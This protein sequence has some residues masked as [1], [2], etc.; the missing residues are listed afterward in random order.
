MTSHHWSHLF[1]FAGF[2]GALLGA[3][4]GLAEFLPISSSAHLVL[5]RWILGWSEF[6]GGP[7]VE[8]AFD[9][10]LHAGTFVAVVWYFWNDLKVFFLS[11]TK[12][13][14][15]RLNQKLVA[16]LIVSTI[17]GALFGVLF[18]HATESYFSTPKYIA[19]FLLSLGVILW[20]AEA[21]SGLNRDLEEMTW[22]DAILI[23]LAQA[24]AIFP[25]FSRSGITI[26]AALFLGIKR[27]SAARYSF[28]MSIPIIGGA[29][30]WEG[31]KLMKMH[32]PLGTLLPFGWGLL[33]SAIV[34]YLCIR[35]FLRYL[36]N[37]KLYPFSIYR[38]I[39]GIL[40]LVALH[41]GF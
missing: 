14:Y 13:H 1:S 2:Q 6:V 8:K 39:V 27:G 32:L 25:G 7:V 18:E 33:T 35:F 41:Q 29:V 34:G 19:I 40:V 28:L 10:I 12:T 11:F 15:N 20:I 24:F 38:I 17:P 9:V 4:Q 31:R 26:T 23:G 3:V 21:T 30:L 5:V 36:S 37:G 16:M 22:K